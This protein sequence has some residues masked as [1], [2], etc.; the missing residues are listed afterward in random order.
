MQWLDAIG[1]AICLECCNLLETECAV[2]DN[3]EVLVKKYSDK[4]RIEITLPREG[5][6]LLT[7]K[8]QK[9]N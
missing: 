3:K 1:L 7:Q 6:F 8:K 9:Q 5:D 2:K 4:I